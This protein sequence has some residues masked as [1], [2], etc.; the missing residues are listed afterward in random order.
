MY[1]VVFVL[2]TRTPMV[3]EETDKHIPMLGITD[4][5]IRAGT[6]GSPGEEHAVRLR[7][8]EKAV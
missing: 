2:A 5:M 3:W 7:G 6:F 8:P 4:V 1:E